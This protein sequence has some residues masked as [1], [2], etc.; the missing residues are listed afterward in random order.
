MNVKNKKGWK[1]YFAD[2]IN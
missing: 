1:E 2:L